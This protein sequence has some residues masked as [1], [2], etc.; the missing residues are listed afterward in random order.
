MILF[1][2][3]RRRRTPGLGAVPP[4]NLEPGDDEPG[5]ADHH[6]ERFEGCLLSGRQPHDLLHQEFKVGLDHSEVDVLGIP[7]WLD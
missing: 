5:R 2:L 3:Y 7:S 1:G 6:V 4:E